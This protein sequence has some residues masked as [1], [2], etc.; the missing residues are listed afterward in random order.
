MSA[1]NAI[2]AAMLWPLA[3]AL[4]IA[5]AGRVSANLR[6]TVTMVTATGLIVIVWSLLPDVQGGGRPAVSVA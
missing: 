5:L 4:G 3:G 2:V 6:E 1:E